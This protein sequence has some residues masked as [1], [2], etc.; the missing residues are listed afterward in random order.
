MVETADAV[1]VGGGLHGC[2]AA[3]HLAR[4]GV[5]PL[6]IEKDHVGRHASGVNA[7]GVRRLGRDLAE[8][9]LSAASME[10]WHGIEDLV[11]DDCGFSRD[12]PSQNCGNGSGTRRL[13]GAGAAGPRTRFRS[14]NDRRQGNPARNAARRSAALYRRDA[15]RGGRS[16]G[17]GANYRCLPAKRRSNGRPFLRRLHGDRSRTREWRVAGDDVGRR[18]RRA[19]A[20]QLRWRLGRPDCRRA[21]R[22]RAVDGQ[23]LDDDGHGADAALR[24]TGGRIAGPPS[25][26]S[27]S[28]RMGR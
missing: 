5:K 22:G 10:L 28:R 23:G 27:S 6:V 17:S 12:R 11:E 18:F 20:G 2:S 9:P 8:I 19:G 26:P 7:G 16:C 14:R 13:V 24:R 21:G 15:C 25:S 3:L 1:I 4:R